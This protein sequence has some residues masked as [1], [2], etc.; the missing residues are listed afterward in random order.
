VA[1]GVSLTVCSGHSPNPSARSCSLSWNPFKVFGDE[2]DVFWLLTYRATYL[3][4]C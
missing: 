3:V 2:A 1:S 4:L